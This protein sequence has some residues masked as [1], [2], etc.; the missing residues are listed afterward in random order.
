VALATALFVLGLVGVA[1]TP[2]SAAPPETAWRND[3]E[4][5]LPSLPLPN[6]K[7][8]GVSPS[9]D[10]KDCEGVSFDFSNVPQVIRPVDSSVTF[11]T[12]TR[13][14]DFRKAADGGGQSITFT[15][16]TPQTPNV[17]SGG[18]D[19]TSSFTFLWPTILDG[20]NWANH[21]LKQRG[22]NEQWSSNVEGAAY[23]SSSNPPHPLFVR[24][25]DCGNPEAYTTTKSCTYDVT[26]GD[27]G[28][29]V[30]KALIYRVGLLAN[31]SWNA[32]DSTS[33]DPACGGGPPFHC[34]TAPVSGFTTFRTDPPAPL[35]ANL[36]ALRT[37]PKQFTFIGTRST[38]DVVKYS[39]FS[40]NPAIDTTGPTLDVNIDDYDVGQ[41]FTGGSMRLQVTDKWNRS[42]FAFADFSVLQ[43]VG[44]QGPIKIKSQT[45]KEVKDG[46]ATLEV[47]VENTTNDTVY[48]VGVISKRTPTGTGITTSPA[49][50]TIPGKGTATFTVKVPTDGRTELDVQSE[51]FGLSSTSSNLRTGAITTHVST[52][53]SVGPTC[54]AGTPVASSA[55]ATSVT[56]SLPHGACP[57]TGPA[58]TGYHLVTYAGTSAVAA[59]T[60]DVTTATSTAT[61][62]GLT[63][64]TTYRFRLVAFD[65]DGSGP[66]GT[67]S[68]YALPP[69]PT[70]DSFT[71]RQYLDFTNVAPTTAQKS[72]WSTKLGA[73]TLTAAGAIDQAVDLPYWSR[74][75]PV[76]RL[77]QAYFGRLPDLGG[78]NHWTNKSR[79]GTSINVISS[80]FAGSSEFKTKYGSLSNAAFVN[81][82]YQN[83]LGRAGDAGGV[84]HWTG[85]LDKKTKTRGQ[86]MVGFSESNEYKTKMQP[87]VD[88]V[89]L[90]TGM[91][92][93]V[94]TKAESG[95]WTPQLKSGTPRTTLIAALLASAAYDARVP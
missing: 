17:T 20:G 25:S 67:V 53:P 88:V 29:R 93:R 15:W 65:G 45:V 24:S 47:V 81:L 94:T 36:D 66:N 4:L 19:Y 51:G 82:V 76:I 44:T 13:T 48:R 26:W 41:F 73:G 79:G 87:T 54:K 92:R 85:V 21:Y 43:Q 84:A 58:P 52:G 57:G 78:L 30:Q 60:Q 1:G 39:W 34:G 91:L 77:F 62:T 37:G 14:L 35:Q 68:A 64:G 69:F 56:V 8:S 59:K 3:A 83:V 2:A 16:Q 74:Q 50:A 75:D 61:V 46:I 63:A 70:L 32:T 89:D 71:N 27:Y 5:Q 49:D 11:T 40:N 55:T 10:T 18:R 28:V 80:N 90:Y 95:Q 9:D 72:D 42:V 38:P 31:F 12:N 7:A 22:T 33:H 6:C 86:V 23:G